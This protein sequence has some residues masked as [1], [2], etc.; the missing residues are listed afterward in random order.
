MVMFLC[1]LFSLLFVS[2]TSLCGDRADLGP[3]R[4]PH[5]V[6]AQQMKVGRCSTNEGQEGGEKK[7]LTVKARTH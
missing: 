7:Q 1:G 4:V 3:C 6:G 5:T 2:L